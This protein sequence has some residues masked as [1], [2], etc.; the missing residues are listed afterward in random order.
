MAY[1]LFNKQA[2][3]GQQGEQLLKE[4]LEKRGNWCVDLSTDKRF[5]LKQDVDFIMWNTKDEFYNLEVK[6]DRMMNKTG[7]MF[8]EI[9]DD[10][11]NDSKGWFAT[12]IADL[13]FYGNATTETFYCFRMTDIKEYIKTHST[14]TISHTDYYGEYKQYRK[15]RMGSLVNVN[16]LIDW[17]K[18]NKKLAFI[19]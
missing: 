6:W 11:D 5:N 16:E 14:R 3:F 9:W 15:I 2:E 10:Y 17:C 1:E 18:E 4:R 13:L 7:N 12:S 19:L 8:L